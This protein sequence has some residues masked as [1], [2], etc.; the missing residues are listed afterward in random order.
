MLFI[1]YTEGMDVVSSGILY[2][3][4]YDDIFYTKENQSYK[5]NSS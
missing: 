4:S 3:A 2:N 1:Y 5:V